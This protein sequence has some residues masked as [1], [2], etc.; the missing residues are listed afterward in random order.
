MLK[1][2]MSILS[3]LIMGPTFYA[4]P[5]QSTLFSGFGELLTTTYRAYNSKKPAEGKTIN[6]PHEYKIDS[7]ALIDKKLCFALE[8]VAT[9]AQKLAVLTFYS[10]SYH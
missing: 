10:K 7:R 3:Y 5:G 8:V 2:F 4:S 1:L 6:G 9:M